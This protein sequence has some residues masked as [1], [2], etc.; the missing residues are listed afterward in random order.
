MEGAD[1]IAGFHATLEGRDGKSFQSPV[2]RQ[3]CSCCHS[4]LFARAP[5]WGDVVSVAASVIDTEL[6]DPP[7]ITHIMLASR[8]SWVKPE[9]GPEDEAFDGLPDKT[10]EEWHRAHGL[11][12][13]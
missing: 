8:A 2:E 12:V 7:L 11:R 6:P 13:E 3:F 1:Y 10:V 5:D 9:I 4:A